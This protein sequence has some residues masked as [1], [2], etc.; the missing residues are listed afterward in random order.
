MR[1]VLF[2]S[3]TAVAVV[4]CA[5]QE[6]SPSLP[7]E[8][9]RPELASQSAATSRTDLGTL[10]GVS[11]FGA[12]V[13]SQG[14]VVGSAQNGAGIKR[15]F[16]W[17]AATGMTDLGTLPGDE[18]SAAISITADGRVLGVSGQHSD[19][20]GRPVIWDPDGNIT[21][22][23]I[24]PLP[25]STRGGP[26]SDM[27]GHGDVVGWDL[28]ALQHGWFWDAQGGKVDITPSF[29]G[30]T[31]ESAASKISP[32]GWVVG[33]ARGRGCPFPS[34]CWR[35]WL[36]S[37]DEGLT[38]LGVPENDKHFSMQAVGVNGAREVVGMASGGWGVLL[39]PWRWEEDSGFTRLPTPGSYG[40]ALSV[41]G[42][43]TAV[44]AANDPVTGNIR[45]AAWSSDGSF[46]RLGPESAAGVAM[47]VSDN[48]FVVGW[49]GLEGVSGVHAIV[50]TLGNAVP[51]APM[52]AGEEGDTTQT[53][54]P[55]AAG[56][57][58]CLVGDSAPMTRGSLL[59]CFRDSIP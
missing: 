10:G 5:C 40:Y 41:N 35:A 33:T 43:G 58:G 14:V 25:G 46:F 3:S 36:W 12:D 8:E 9:G 23:P 17:T 18:W 26:P 22:L 48:G 31:F 44:G 59:Q 24:G 19:A 49:Q 16:R 30:G 50:W 20:L 11:S 2:W 15:A 56:V 38:D 55:S 27:N 52:L 28:F 32:S 57:E 21:A 7:S 34:T 4:L 42:R 54:P 29:P 47:A 6:Q 1:A 39:A 13:N 51:L 37:S 53:P 45:P